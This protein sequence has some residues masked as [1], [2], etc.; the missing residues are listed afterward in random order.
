MPRLLDLFCGAGGAAVGY[1]RAGFDVLGV[2][3]VPHKH[4]PF[5]FRQA[6]AMTFPL[7]GFDVVHA[8][9]PCQDYTAT[10]NISLARRVHPDYPR[11][12]APMRKR[13]Q[14]WGG[15]YVMENVTGAA[16][17]EREMDNP[18]MLCGTHFGLHVE[19]HRYFESNCLLFGA[20]PCAHR[21]GNVSV[22]RK[23]AEYI[24][25]WSGVTYIDSHGRVRKRPKSCRFADAMA[26][27]GIDW[28][29]TFDELGEAIPPAYTE[30]LGR[31]LL[32]IMRQAA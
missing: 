4:Y 25:V 31:Q 1:S 12:L 17:T 10:K 19:R 2:D 22:R 7:D 5:A 27:M 14:E 26:A 23:R 30:W 18:L 8:S 29:M 9:P 21:I 6:D 20:G 24:G 11:L 13:L 3:I 32:Q 15:L 16:L 28:P